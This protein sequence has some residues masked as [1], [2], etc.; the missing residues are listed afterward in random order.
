MKKFTVRFRETVYERIKKYA[1]QEE[2]TVMAAIRQ[3]ITQFF[4]D[5]K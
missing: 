5:K 3:I 2:I 1:A 4:K